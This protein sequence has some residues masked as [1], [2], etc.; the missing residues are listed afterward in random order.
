VLTRQNGHD[1]AAIH[2]AFDV[3][4]HV[5]QVLFLGGPNRVVCEKDEQLVPRE[6]AERM[7]KIDPLGHPGLRAEIAAGRA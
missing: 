5:R 7:V 6:A 4:T 2:I 3:R 1:P